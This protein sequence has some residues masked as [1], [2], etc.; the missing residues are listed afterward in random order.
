MSSKT[1]TARL[2][3]TSKAACINVILY[4]KQYASY[5]HSMQLQ[6]EVK[7]NQIH[8]NC[9]YESFAISLPAQPFLDYHLG[10]HTMGFLEAAHFFIAGLFSIT[11]NFVQLSYS[12]TLFCNLVYGLN[13]T[14]HINTVTHIQGNILDLILANT[15]NDFI[16]HGIVYPHNNQP[17]RSDH[18]LILL[19]WD[20]SWYSWPAQNIYYIAILRWIMLD[21]SVYTYNIYSCLQFDKVKTVWTIINQTLQ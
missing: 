10:F 18:F 5:V 2:L 19:I 15:D 6:K 14:Q 12:L 13:F 1:P 21:C 11:Y 17:I 16:L 4:N 3:T 20:L 8:L 7:S 9:Y